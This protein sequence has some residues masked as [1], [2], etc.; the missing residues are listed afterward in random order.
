VLAPI[1]GSPADRAGIKPGD[2][3]MAINGQDTSGWTGEQAARHLRGMGGT[4]V[5]FSR[6]LFAEPCSEV[7]QKCWAGKRQVC[8]AG[9]A[10]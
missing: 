8:W 4:Q 9:K 1:K 3:V 10:V 6:A 7:V 2:I 5:G